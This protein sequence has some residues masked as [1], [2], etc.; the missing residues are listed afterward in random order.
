MA[1]C[2]QTARHCGL[3]WGWQEA[4][5]LPRAVLVKLYLCSC[6]KVAALHSPPEFTLPKPSAH[7]EKCCTVWAPAAR[8]G[9]LHG[10]GSPCSTWAGVWKELPSALGSG[11]PLVLRERG[12]DKSPVLCWVFPAPQFGL[13]LNFADKGKCGHSSGNFSNPETAL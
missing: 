5:W 4:I 10:Q 12:L 8:A 9:F 6:S 1:Q 3:L 7:R 2:S 11:L 13:A